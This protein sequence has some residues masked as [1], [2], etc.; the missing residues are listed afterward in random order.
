[1]RLC[2]RQ[3]EAGPKCRARTRG[4]T[5]TGSFYFLLKTLGYAVNIRTWKKTINRETRKR[6]LRS[7]GNPR[8]TDVTHD[9]VGRR[10]DE[11]TGLK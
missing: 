8:T 5:E 9:N 10:T 4:G 1:M 6:K 7:L 2:G 3:D 11:N